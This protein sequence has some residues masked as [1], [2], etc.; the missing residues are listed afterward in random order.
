MKTDKESP[1]ISESHLVAVAKE[2]ITHWNL[3]PGL[4]LAILWAFIHR[5][6]TGRTIEEDGFGITKKGRQ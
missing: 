5:A 3:P 2:E 4:V 1:M 6:T